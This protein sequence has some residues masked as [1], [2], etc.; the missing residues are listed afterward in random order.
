MRVHKR[1]KLVQKAEID[2]E[3]ALLGVD[4]HYEELAAAFLQVEVVSADD[5]DLD[6]I[7]QIR[8]TFTAGCEEHELTFGESMRLAGSILQSNAKYVIRHERH[9]NY[10]DP[11]GLE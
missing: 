4:Y 2:I 6:K 9:G 5:M 10:E 11:G 1:V 7:E 8:A 3:V